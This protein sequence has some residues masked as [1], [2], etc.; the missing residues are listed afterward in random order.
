MRAMPSSLYQSREDAGL[1][2]TFTGTDMPH[3]TLTK[4]PEKR[5][6]EGFMCLINNLDI[7][8]RSKA[9]FPRG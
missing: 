7:S 3:S 4:N 5:I 8:G 6:T 1:V 2:G 9:R